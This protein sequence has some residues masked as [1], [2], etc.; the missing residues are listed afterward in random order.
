MVIPLNALSSPPCLFL[1]NSDCQKAFDSAK[2][3]LCSAPLLGA[4]DFTRT[5]KLAV[6]ASVYGADAVLLQEYH[7][8]IDHPVCY[9]S[10]KFNKHQINYSTIEKETLALLLA[11][12]HFQNYKPWWGCS[13]IVCLPPSVHLGSFSGEHLVIYSF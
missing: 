13:H 12:Q 3:L 11:L 2:A 1:W 9:F 10:K 5:F 6:D 7:R 4:L 8:G